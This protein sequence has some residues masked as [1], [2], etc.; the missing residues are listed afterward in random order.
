MTPQ[1]IPFLSV[2]ALRTAL[3][4]REFT[5][6]DVVDSLA[7][8]IEKIDP[9]IHAYLSKDLAE[10][11]QA[12]AAADVNLPLG[13]IP[14]GMKDVLSVKG[15]PCGCASRIL[16]GYIAPYD[17]TAVARF[18]AAGAI[19]FGRLNM[20]EFAMGSSTENS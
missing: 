3:R 2:A 17:A 8:R 14:I 12:A 20:D 16:D 10:A 18:R 4:A 9:Q 6:T 19:P 5:P 1:E 15:H 13:G 11:R 7:A